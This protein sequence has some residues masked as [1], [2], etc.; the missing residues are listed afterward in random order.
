MKD[1]IE[2]S[3]EQ[4]ERYRK[5]LLYFIFFTGIWLLFTLIMAISSGISIFGYDLNEAINSEDH[6]VFFEK[7]NET[8]KRYILISL[9][10]ILMVSAIFIR[11]L[12]TDGLTR[13]ELWAFVYQVSGCF[14]FGVGFIAYLDLNF[15][16]HDNIEKP[17]FTSKDQIEFQKSNSS[18]NA[19]FIPTGVFIQSIE[20]ISANNVKLTGYVWQKYKRG[21]QDS[22][23]R[24]FIIPEAESSTITD[25]YNVYNKD[26]SIQT[27]GWYFEAVTREN[28]DYSNYPF[29]IQN[30]WF[31]LWHK[32]FDKN[33][34]LAADFSSYKDPNP[35]KL[36]GLDEH[37]ITPG[38]SLETSFFSYNFN[39]YNTNFGIEGTHNKDNFPELYFNVHIKR[40]FLAALVTDIIPIMLVLLIML[41]TFEVTYANVEDDFFKF[42]MVESLSLGTA[43]LFV[44]TLS[45][46][47]LRSKI[48]SG[49]ILYIEYIYFAVYGGILWVMSYSILSRVLDKLPP[50]LPQNGLYAKILF[51]PI[52][53]M[54]IYVITLLKFY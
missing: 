22:I 30:V 42:N 25:A 20:F 41:L 1:Y 35:V 3:S 53:S 43:L 34:I 9:P 10:F 7:M 23:Q 8:R 46:Y 5:Y 50:W 6:F 2:F 27:I 31:R 28:F 52:M 11:F 29:D 17:I 16:S 49:S 32:E 24:G 15:Y 18:K 40:A 4:I 38:W 51:L 33:I 54:V 26:S 13:N 12:L 48:Q 19:I 47:E 37:L 36:P 45:Q 39:S 21:E 14:I 44:L